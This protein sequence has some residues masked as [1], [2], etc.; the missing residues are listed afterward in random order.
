MARFT[1]GVAA[2]YRSSARLGPDRQVDR[3][4]QIDAVVA[5]GLR[6]DVAAEIVRGPLGP[7]EGGIPVGLGA[8]RGANLWLDGPMALPGA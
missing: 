2:R 5:A 1:C 7:N 6:L 3:T 8:R 4:A